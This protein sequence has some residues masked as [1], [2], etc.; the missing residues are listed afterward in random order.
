LQVAAKPSPPPV[1]AV[2]LQSRW[3]N[4]LP[5]HRD[6]YYTLYSWRADLAEAHLWTTQSRRI[7]TF[8]QFVPEC[9]QW[10]RDSIVLLVSSNRTGE[11]GGLLRAYNMNPIDGWVWLQVYF[12]P[13]MR[14]RPF[15]V[16]EALAAF[17][18]YLF[19]A[20][21]IRKVI[22]EVFS[23]NESGLQLCDRLGF[24]EVGKFPEHIWWKDRYWD[25][26]LYELTRDRWTDLRE[27]LPVLLDVEHMMDQRHGLT[28]AR[29]AS[30]NGHEE[31]LQQGAGNEA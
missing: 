31:P 29:G 5:V 6:H 12:R 30:I 13:E 18:Q 28:G 4:L 27:R 14:S 7:L 17:G 16:A 3:V 23:F 21:P 9:D 8:E 11:L 26:F 2:S 15:V 25:S 22:A 19:S 10:L 20:L 24:L 1:T